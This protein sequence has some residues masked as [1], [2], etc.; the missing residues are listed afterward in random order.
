MNSE[1]D[2][3][4]VQ[5]SILPSGMPPK[6]GLYDPTFEKDACGVGFVVNIKGRRSHTIVRYAMQVLVNLNHRGACGC[7]ANTGDGAGI[8]MQLPDKFLRKVAAA[9]GCELPPVG[10]YGVGMVFL[11][12]D[13]AQR[14]IFEAEFE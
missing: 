5:P 1:S 10:E 7:E 12:K 13:A 2:Q 6:Q 3:R 11:P 8:N 14:A 9:C 4:G